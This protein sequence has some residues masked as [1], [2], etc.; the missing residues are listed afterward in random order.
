MNFTFV[1]PVDENIDPH[2]INSYKKRLKR[3]K[4]KYAQK[5]KK[6]QTTDEESDL[7]IISEKSD[8]SF[9]EERK[10]IDDEDE[11]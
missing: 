9:S 1:S 6:W 11:D 4:E 2:L 5:G 7:Y 8:S 10:M 3:Q